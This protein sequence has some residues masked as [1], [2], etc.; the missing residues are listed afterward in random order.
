MSN[1]SS[2]EFW[3]QDISLPQA[4]VASLAV[5]PVYRAAVYSWKILPPCI[6]LLGGF[7]NIA[8]IF[9]MRRIKD[10]NSSQC[11]IFMALAMSDLTLLCTDMTVT[12]IKQVSHVDLLHLHVAV[13]KVHLW[14]THT[15]GVLSAW[16]VTFVTVQRTM[17]VLWPHR[18]RVM[19]T[20]R[21][22]WIVIVTLVVTACAFDFH[23]L[24]GME[25][26]QENSL[27]SC[28]SFLQPVQADMEYGGDQLYQDT[29][30]WRR[31]SVGSRCQQ[32]QF[33]QQVLEANK[34]A[35]GP[36]DFVHRVTDILATTV[37]AS[38]LLFVTLSVPVV[39]I[40]IGVKYLDD[41]P[42]EK[43]IPV[44]L[45]VGGCFLALKL[46]G[47]L[48]KNVLLRRYENMDAFYDSSD[49]ELVFT[50]RTFLM[51]D[52]ILSA[53][54]LAWHLVGAYWVFSIWMPP[55]RPELHQ[56]SFYCGETVYFCAV[57]EIIATGVL[58]L[59]CLLLCTV[60]ALC[61]KYTA[62]FEQ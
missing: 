51:M 58:L 17:A 50:S 31:S 57:V 4:D 35:D 11:A 49:T 20:M 16:L 36:W 29:D 43:R 13:C 19:C 52:W 61:Y 15:S 62:A 26:T 3:L 27:C 7:G 45:L 48:W 39:M 12:W 53:F 59:L 30:G 40:I 24:L 56:P 1:F 54:L 44:Y 21:R 47:M 32:S 28:R 9:V 55:F 46:I 2:D 6:L 37:V 14:V 38:M 60:L 34:D 25:I 10:H 8:T 33:L 5:Y 18:M 42:L 41:C 22:T 23:L